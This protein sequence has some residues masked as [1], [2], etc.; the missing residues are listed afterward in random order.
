M[1][2]N[3]AK[4]RSFS[5]LLVLAL[6]VS[7]LGQV[8]AQ[9]RPLPRPG[10]VPP[11][12][13]TTSGW[14]AFEGAN[15]EVAG[16]GAKWSSAGQPLGDVAARVCESSLPTQNVDTRSAKVNGGPI[17]PLGGD[18]WHMT[19]KSR[20]SFGH[21]GTC[22]FRTPPGKADMRSVVFALQ[23]FVAVRARGEG[24]IEVRGEDD[25]IVGSVAVTPQIG[26]VSGGPLTPTMVQSVIDTRKGVGKRGRIVVVPNANKTIEI[27]DVRVY[28]DAPKKPSLGR[29]QGVG[30][31]AW[32][33]ADLHVHLATHQAMGGLD[34]V[35]TMWGVPGGSFKD[36]VTNPKL[37]NRDIP[38]CNGYNHR[39]GVTGGN[40]EGFMGAGLV[41]GMAGNIPDEA[42][43]AAVHGLFHHDQGG[44]GVHRKQHYKDGFHQQHHITA[45]RRA[46][47]GG[48]RLMGAL[49]NHS[50]FM[51]LLMGRVRVENGR[52]VVQL[53]NELELA[54]AHVCYVQQLA[55]LNSDWMEVAYSADDA[56]RIIGNNKLALII[57]LE[58]PDAG[59]LVRNA[60]PEQE[61][62]ELYAL[63]I[64]QITLIH[65]ANNK[66]GGTQV[67][68]D[69]YD[70]YNDEM[71]TGRDA[72]N[73]V[74][75]SI[76]EA[77]KTTPSYIVPREGGCGAP[78][79]P[80][81]GQR[82]ECVLYNLGHLPLR[83]VVTRLNTLLG[84]TV[85]PMVMT[86]FFPELQLGLGP[87][88]AA[89]G[90]GVSVASHL[91]P[92]FPLILPI[93]SL[94]PVFNTPTGLIAPQTDLG[95]TMI[96]VGSRKEKAIREGR[97]E[98]NSAGLTS[99]GEDYVKAMMSR[100]MM[101]DLA[102][103]SDLS[104]QRVFELS[105]T[106]SGDAK[107]QVSVVNNVGEVKRIARDKSAQ[108]EACFASAYPLMI[109]H[110][111]IRSQSIQTLLVDE[112]TETV[113]AFVA[114]PNHPVATTN[115]NWVP[116][117][118]E[119]SDS[120]LL[121]MERVGGIVG[122]FMG[123]DGIIDP[124][125]NQT[126]IRTPNDCAN[127]TTGF[128]WAYAY[129][130][131]M[132]NGHGAALSS[133]ATYHDMS[134]PRFGPQACMTDL[135]PLGSP[136]QILNP[137]FFR[138]DKQANAVRYVGNQTSAVAQGRK[139]QPPLTQFRQDGLVWDYNTEGWANY[140]IVPDLLQDA[141]NLGLDESAMGTM[142]RSAQD[143]VDAWAK[144]TRVSHCDEAGGKCADADVKKQDCGAVCKGTCP[145]DDNAGA[146]PEAPNT[147]PAC[148]GEGQRACC[149]GETGYPCRAGLV[150]ISGCPF[151][152]ASCTC[153]GSTVRASSQCKAPSACGGLGERACCIG[154]A[155]F[156]TCKGNG[157]AVDG[158]TMGEEKCK[159]GKGSLLSSSQHCEGP[160]APCGGV[161]E[162]A[163]CVGE[164]GYACKPGAREVNG[165]TL[166]N[167][168]CR[169]GKS[170]S[171]LASSHCEANIDT[172]CGGVGQRACCV[173]ETGYA[174]K[175]GA[176]EI[177]GC[178]GGAASCRCGKGSS[179]LASSRCEANV[180]T[181]CGGVGQRA[182]CIGETG[183]ACR[184]GTQ[185]MNGCPYGEANCRCGKGSSSLASSRCET[186]PPPPPQPISSP[187][188]EKG[189]RACCFGE[190]G[191]ACKA[192]AREVA[193]CNL[194][195][196][197]C[198]CGKGST[199]QA[200]SRCQ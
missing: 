91:V 130:H 127:S 68:Q 179:A 2:T 73:R 75:R 95:A 176:K 89:A 47:E 108:N 72:Q 79:S 178:N 150:E 168:S 161:G 15:A 94:T 42:T 16:S 35:R 105:R 143:Y 61:V 86:S 180:D 38:R 133:D 97:G 195:T 80:V 13:P 99:R 69:V 119:I 200:S 36:Y 46:Y 58:L 117:E 125:G 170:S 41:G 53:T 187:C 165:C 49:A 184:P 145:K 111:Q 122:I 185:E 103:A 148:G 34:G 112:K 156:G 9:P 6:A 169:C 109:S 189:Q 26:S 37:I 114:R 7:V 157:V 28:T 100:G 142:F 137:Q 8:G 192:G 126:L 74:T 14:L 158:C 172:P 66:L 60:T 104:T 40:P 118:F 17:V 153:G 92:L 134:G 174:C 135:N 22:W 76:D 88:Q 152:A 183:F 141:K 98:L 85:G 65:G 44:A 19:H 90:I 144:A 56:Q 171:A 193:G 182:C 162:R 194:G 136:E 87:T 51:E 71:W 154:E 139:D 101:I 21:Q 11:P 116:R 138:A 30:A 84:N 96:A 149:V 151:G 115:K 188:G 102:H 197:A 39:P 59:N 167:A 50:E 32:G 199:V 54:R 67:F 62:S 198:R 57:G 52:E 177:P 113:K 24:R 106:A 121:W 173:G 29:D 186:P 146:P 70:W 45:I 124:P 131:Q 43:V 110:T 107:C 191:Y 10:P 27:D 93:L 1:F 128:A 181:P 175:P 140:G 83:P 120:Q 31:R 4:A 3:K 155:A 63:G 166:G 48:L 18:Y 64:R 5:L 159:C 164:T 123:Q 77:K 25:A 78:D 23:P 55:E 129:A 12:Q 20:P 196:V 132:L 190:T 81:K 163:C 33:F 147:T 160:A 82:G